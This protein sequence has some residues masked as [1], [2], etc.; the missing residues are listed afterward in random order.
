MNITEIQQAVYDTYGVTIDNDDAAYLAQEAQVTPET[1][2]ETLFLT[3]VEDRG[4]VPVDEDGEP[5]EPADLERALWGDDYEPEPSYEDFVTDLAQ[6]T[7]DLEAQLGYDAGPE[8]SLSEDHI[9]M[10]N[11]QLVAAA[12]AASVQVR[13][14]WAERAYK[15]AAN[16]GVDPAEA[17][18]FVAQDQDRYDEAWQ[19]AFDQ[20][21][22]A[23]AAEL[24][25][26]KSGLPK[27]VYRELLEAHAAD[28]E[29]GEDY[30]DFEPDV[31]A[32]WTDIY[33]EPQNP[34]AV[35]E[36][37]KKFDVDEALIRA[38]MKHDLQYLRDQIGRHGVDQKP[39]TE[40]DVQRR[41]KEYERQLEELQSQ[42]LETLN[43]LKRHSAPSPEALRAERLAEVGTEDAHSPVENEV[44]VKAG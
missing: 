33:G 43:D 28:V 15:L 12:K 26:E 8:Q 31:N 17:I 5:V 2:P 34:E 20:Q 25:L 11:H 37:E 21:V 14:P 36:T 38:N 6:R 39:V 32:V 7:A 9:A 18:A 44:A 10:I 30:R 22:A 41:Q 4:I 35:P 27:R 23:K 29:E 16:E 3:L 1:D 42:R 40:E 24:G 13:G 19:T